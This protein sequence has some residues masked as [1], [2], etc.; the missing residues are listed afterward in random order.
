MTI[1]ER[2][3]RWQRMVTKLKHSSGAKLVL[4]VP[5]YTF[6]NPLLAAAASKPVA[7]GAALALKAKARLANMRPLLY[8]GLHL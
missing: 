2:R 1:E 6:E 4:R 3:E 7:D 5:T 8:L